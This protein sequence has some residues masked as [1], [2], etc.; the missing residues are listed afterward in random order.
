MN[1]TARSAAPA[2][3]DVQM[4]SDITLPAEDD[5]GTYELCLQAGASEGGQ[6][7]FSVDSGPPDFRVPSLQERSV[8]DLAQGRLTDSC[9]RFALETSPSTYSG[10]VALELG[11]NLGELSM[12]QA[13]LRRC[14]QASF[15][16][17]ALPAV[18]R[19]YI[20]PLQ[21]NLGCT[22]LDDLAGSEFELNALGQETDGKYNCLQRLREYNDCD[23]F[24][25]A[26]G[27][28]KLWSCQSRSALRASATGEEGSA[29]VYSQLC[30]YQEPWAGRNGA[31]PR[32]PVF[33]KLWEWNF[34]DVARECEDFLGPNGF[35]AVQVAPVTEHIMGG[36]WFAKYQPVSFLLNSRSGTAEEFKCMVAR[37]RA[38]GLEVIVDIIINHIAK[39][40]DAVGLV[41][42][43]AVTPCVGWAGSRYG[44]RRMK[45]AAPDWPAVGP[46]YFHHMP[47]DRL[48]NCAVTPITFQCPDSTPR[49]DCTQCDL[50]GLPD[51]N[52]GLRDVQELLAKHVRELHSIGVTMIRLDAPSYVKVVDFSLIL[53]VVPWDYVFQEWWG[54]LPERSR[55]RYVGH[56]RDIIYGRKIVAQLAGPN[57]TNLGALL[58]ITYGLE[59]MRPDQ[60]LYPLAFHDER[61]FRANSGVATYKNGLQ[62]HQQQKYMLASPAGVV[63]RLWGGFG[64]TNLDDGPP[65]CTHLDER[66]SPLPVFDEQGVSACLATPTTIPL[67]P[68][69]ANTQRWICEHRWAGTAGLISFRKACRGL[70]I[71][72]R[73]DD[74]VAKGN[75]AWRTG[76]TCF[77]A[78]QRKLNPR[79]VFTNWSFVG[80]ET[81]LPAGRYCDLASLPTRKGWNGQSCPNEVVLGAGGV[82]VTGAVPEGDLL[83]I[84]A[85]GRLPDAAAA[86]AF[87]APVRIRPHSVDLACTITPETL[88]GATGLHLAPGI[89]LAALVLGALRRVF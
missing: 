50:F 23:T 21:E 11:G 77:V 36:T 12:C 9:F 13:S 87:A 4:M 16:P 38:A 71:T 70:P 3:Y 82:V 51:W 67:D 65:G 6:I 10:R 15:L 84:H 47:T 34:N 40:C 61:S 86:A 19:C 85:G 31:T 29:V 1:V 57:V 30:E 45:E 48:R 80:L 59:G 58:N 18:R 33:V 69:L 26:V 66:C 68:D 32:S 25:F 49:G 42:A 76:E 54:G 28:C 79:T 2:L 8:M 53:N 44:N 41:G 81:G 37:C 24:T 73:W 88:S 74:Q 89:A 39:P 14:R 5:S 46:D 7:R 60:A 17:D 64:W 52:T 20:S 75:L 72:R 27:R 55:T 63:V 43:D 62:F 56:V 78:L 83:A 35:D 22:M